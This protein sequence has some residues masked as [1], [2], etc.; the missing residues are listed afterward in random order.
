[1]PNKFRILD[2]TLRDGGYYNNW[3]FSDEFVNAYFHAVQKSPISII[4]IGFR[5]CDKST[6]KGPLAY[7]TTEYL[8]SFKIIPK[9]KQMHSF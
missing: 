9:L 2:C 6:F 7:T 8:S 4:E 3:D 5:S 1:M